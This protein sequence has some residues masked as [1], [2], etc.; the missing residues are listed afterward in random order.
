MLKYKLKSF[1]YRLISPNIIIVK[2]NLYNQIKKNNNKF[3][4]TKK[5]TVNKKIMEKKFG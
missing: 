2:R 3:I 5:M 4:N 1:Y